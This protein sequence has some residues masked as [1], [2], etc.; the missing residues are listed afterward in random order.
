MGGRWRGIGGRG[1]PQGRVWWGDH[2]PFWPR[3]PIEGRFLAVDHEG[4]R[5]PARAC[6]RPPA[7]TGADRPIPLPQR[8]RRFAT[9]DVGDGQSATPGTEG[10]QHLHPVRVGVGP[11]IPASGIVETHFLQDDDLTWGTAACALRARPERRNRRAGR[12]SG[13]ICG[14]R[15]RYGTAVR[16]GCGRRAAT[17]PNPSSR[18]KMLPTPATSA[19]PLTA[20]PAVRAL[21]DGSRGSGR[22]T[23]S[24]RPGSSGTGDGH[25]RATVDVEIHPATSR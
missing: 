17:E 23:V 1:G 8:L 5:Q 2:C 12:R 24:W 20:R 3:P 6:A 15:S 10:G 14:W 16:S 9:D 19:R 22:T 4:G 21:P 25:V 13:G 11:G 7:A 18:R